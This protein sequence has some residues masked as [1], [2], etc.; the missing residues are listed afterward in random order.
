MM[1]SRV[2]RYTSIGNPTGSSSPQSSAI[3][4]IG[5]STPQPMLIIRSQPSVSTSSTDFGLRPAVLIPIS[6]STVSEFAATV[7][8]GCVPAEAAS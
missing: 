3:G 1:V 4:S 6:S 8:P 7:V 5:H 2:L